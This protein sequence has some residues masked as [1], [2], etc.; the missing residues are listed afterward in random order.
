VLR[1][2]AGRHAVTLVS[3]VRGD[4]AE[5]VEHLRQTCRAVHVL[6]LRRGRVRDLW[7][8]GRSLLAGESFLMTRDARAEMHRMIRRLAVEDSFDIVHVDQLNM[9]QYAGDAPGTAR[10]LDAHNALWLVAER[11]ARTFGLG[12]HRLLLEREARLLRTYEGRVCREFE[13]V[14][15]VSEEDRLALRQAAGDGVPIEVVPI[16]VDVAAIPFAERARDARQILHI[17]SLLWPPTADGLDWFLREVWPRL[18]DRRPQL[19]LEIVGGDPPPDLAARAEAGGA[20]VRGYVADPTPWWRDAALM[21][22]PLRAG[23]GVRVRILEGLARGVP[24]VATA[25]GCEGIAVENEHHL[26]VADAPDAFAAA[27]LRLLDVPQLAAALARS[28]RALVEKRYDFRIACHAI[29][30]VYS[31]AVRRRHAKGGGGR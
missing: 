31:D 21:V 15:A 13:G 24:I 12:P 11:L 4:Q 26:L 9:A 5:D 10:V 27:V 16:A 22:V 23:G 17:G 2:L 1:Y 29:D 19:S 25:M 18:R 7:S 3:F 8:M 20:H 14:L 30:G 6:P 28:G